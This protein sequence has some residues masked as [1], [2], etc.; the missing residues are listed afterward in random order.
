MTE[1][2]TTE[3]EAAVVEPWSRHANGRIDTRLVGTWS[4]PDYLGPF[5]EDDEVI[6]NG[7]AM[8]G[9]I[10]LATDKGILVV[11]KPP[12]NRDEQDPGAWFPAGGIT[13]IA[14]V[15]RMLVVRAPLALPDEP[16]G[17]PDESL[18]MNP[19]PALPPE[20]GIF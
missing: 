17:E 14:P 4:V 8:V 6:V 7:G 2:S 13:S 19:P 20:P 11:P 3:Q 5:R 12:E 1:P 18:P 16:T 9:V 15:K 10:E